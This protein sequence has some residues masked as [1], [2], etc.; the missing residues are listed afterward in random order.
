V[1]DL[2]GNI[3]L[4]DLIGYFG[5]SLCLLAYALLQTGKLSAETLSYSALNG[6]GAAGILISLYFEPNLPS[7]LMEGTWLILSLFGLY[8]VFSTSK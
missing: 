5:V 7:I 6:F 2:F 1:S 3:T 8:R 4:P